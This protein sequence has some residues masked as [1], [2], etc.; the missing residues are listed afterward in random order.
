MIYYLYKEW[1][2]AGLVI[3]L[4]VMEKCMSRK[5]KK[6]RIHQNSNA[7]Q[8]AENVDAEQRVSAKKISQN[9][10][11][12][13]PDKKTIEYKIPSN[14]AASNIPENM[15]KWK[16]YIKI[17]INFLVAILIFLFI[18]LAVPKLLG[19]FIPFVIGWVIAM[20]CNPLVKL[21][22]RK[23]KIVRKFSSALIIIVV[24]GAVILL[25]YL[26]CS[27]VIKQAASMIGNLDNIYADF[28]KALTSIANDLGD[29]YKLF[30][31]K[32]TE[33]IEN[34]FL[35]LDEYITQFLS[36]VKGPTIEDASG[37]VKAVAHGFFMFIITVISSFFFIAEKDHMLDGFKKWI[38][39][40]A[41][42]YYNLITSNFKKAVG[43]YFKAQF[44]IMVI[45]T[46]ILF[47]GLT[48][49]STDYALLLA[50]LIA[51]LDFLPVFGT[52]T[53]ICPWAIINIINERYEEAVVLLVLYVIC[54]LV[55]QLLQ[56][57][58]VG[59]SIGLSPLMTMFF[60]F[61]GYRFG[62]IIGIIIGIPIGMI[63]VNLYRAGL[64][65]TLIRGFKIVVNDINEFR[66]F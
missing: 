52:G 25:L 16:L 6:H 5:P 53:V 17:G 13:V 46:I 58:M 50:L 37:V 21:L 60:L 1:Y 20:I 12:I 8:G 55:K 44:K 49:I 33:G 3:F 57:K 63:L 4:L 43:G 65:D 41:L 47:I 38:P 18:V 15:P 23:L 10:K 42:N 61:I 36:N 40:S 64:F 22:E 31:A 35:H 59:D 26:I 66:K 34:F 62:G 24:L 30:P 28:E 56:P 2:F 7:G 14:P 48:I 45:I 54:Q 27:Q 9:I 29:K 32:I 11:K 19:F 39:S 51:F